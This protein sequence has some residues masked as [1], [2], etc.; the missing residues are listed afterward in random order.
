MNKIKFLFK[1]NVSKCL[2]QAFFKSIKVLFLICFAFLFCLISGMFF[3]S[4]MGPK[5]R[6]IIADEDGLIIH[7]YNVFTADFERCFINRHRGDKFLEKYD[8]SENNETLNCVSSYQFTEKD[9]V[10]AMID[11]IAERQIKSGYV[12]RSD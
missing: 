4:Q 9:R 3:Y 7:R 2:N 1:E 8:K 6:Y 12:E 11:E 10:N 5:Y